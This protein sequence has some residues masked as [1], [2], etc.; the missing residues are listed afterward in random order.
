MQPAT[1]PG[2]DAL[3]F[4]DLLSLKKYRRRGIG[5]AL[6]EQVILASGQPRVVS[7]YRQDPLAAPFWQALLGQLPLRAVQRLADADQP[8]L[9][10]CPINQRPP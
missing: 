1:R 3:E 5:R 8:E 2:V 9:L 6:V 4:A 7:L 10:T